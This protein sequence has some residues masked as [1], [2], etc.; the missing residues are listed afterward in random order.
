MAK[1]AQVID[2]Q[3]FE[4]SAEDGGIS[5]TRQ[6]S[7][8]IVR[9]LPG[10]YLDFEDLCKVQIGSRD[11]ENPAL[12]CSSYTAE[13]DGEGRMVWLVT[14][15]YTWRPHVADSEQDNG[16]PYEPPG[17]PS[18]DAN[19]IE[20]SFPTPSDGSANSKAP[21][22]RPANWYIQSSLIEVPAYT[23]KPVTGPNEGQGWQVPKNTAKDL[24]EGITK[25][26]PA[27]SIHVQQFMWPDPTAN[28]M[29]VGKVNKEHW[30]LGQM[31]MLPRTV[32]F[33]A[34]NTQPHIEAFGG[35][36]YRGWMTTYEFLY[37]RNWIEVEGGLADTI[38][39]DWA[40]P[41]S[42][43]NVLAF[44]PN[45][46]GQDRDLYGQPLRHASGRIPI[47]LTLPD[48]IASGDKVRAMVRIAEVEGGIT[49]LPSAQ[50]V[51]LN[52]DGT[53]RISTATPPVL[54]YRYQIYEELDFDLLNVRLQ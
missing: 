51:A 49:Q 32:M 46:A 15:T 37:R 7:F 34:M 9:D 5:T 3:R 27:V 11:A 12:R 40:Q 31:V 21:D 4:R 45:N 10:E 16:S 41:Q 35:K 18:L 38:G 33:R 36:I 24:Y 8:R 1:V 48:G 39:W 26:E 20:T 29:H 47:P 52:D 22:I 6:K 53:P 19:G 54:V 13:P 42:G 44:N 23:W 14:F 30:P 2:G 50:P 28:A 43:F 25:L 17:A